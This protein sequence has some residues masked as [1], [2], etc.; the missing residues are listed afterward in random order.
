MVVVGGGGGWVTRSC[1]STPPHLVTCLIKHRDHLAFT[2]HRI[3]CSN[4]NQRSELRHDK[5][6]GDHK[7]RSLCMCMLRNV[8]AVT[9]GGVQVCSDILPSGLCAMKPTW[10]QAP[11]LGP[12]GDRS[13]NT[14]FY[15]PTRRRVV[16]CG[17]AVCSELRH[18]GRC[19]CFL[20]QIQKWRRAMLCG[21]LSARVA[22]LTAPASRVSNVAID[23]CC[24]F[25]SE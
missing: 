13:D 15:M 5:W 11:A 4:R 24:I 6:A 9:C 25:K 1:T 23:V 19:A 14:R 20:R 18:F 3:R 17:N 8:A 2:F 22:N 16:A 21:G 7:L 10:R 12:H